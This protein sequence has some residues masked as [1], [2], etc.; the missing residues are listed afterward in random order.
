M[1][2]GLRV[3]ACCLALVAGP[4]TTSARAA[5]LPLWELGLG[6]GLLSLPHYRGSDQTHTWLL[7]VPYAVYRGTIFRADRDGARARLIESQR[8]KLDLSVAASPPTRSQDNRARE[9]M[10]DLAPTVELGPNLNLTLQRGAH[11]KLDL[12]LPLRAVATI[13]RHP[14]GLGWSASPVL[15][16]DITRGGWNL[17]L[18]AGA[19]WNSRRLNGYFYDVAD[20]QVLPDRPAYRADQGYAGWQATVALSRRFAR[21]WTGLFLRWDT[22]GGAVFESSPL[23][24]RQSAVSMGV[25]WSWIEWQSGQRV[26][27]PD[28]HP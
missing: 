2:R 9:G 26:Q 5:D 10:P 4:A 13:E 16:L 24:R 14:Q 7:P 1:T 22:V 19:S 3:T 23:V 27:V 6:A 25:A 21:H 18:Q 8:V 11:W 15:N 12:R 28:D 20:D 17:G